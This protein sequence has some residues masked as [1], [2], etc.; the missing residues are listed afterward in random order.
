MLSRRRKMLLDMTAGIELEMRDALGAKIS[1]EPRILR[2]AA[3]VAWPV[4]SVMVS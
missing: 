2:D 3:P 4:P 1:P